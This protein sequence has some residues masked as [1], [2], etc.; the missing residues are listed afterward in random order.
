MAPTLKPTETIRIL[1][2][3]DQLV[4]KQAMARLLAR[5]PEVDCVGETLATNADL[6]YIQDRQ[7]HVVLLAQNLT[8]LTTLHTLRAALPETKI[9]AMPLLDGFG[10][11]KAVLEAGA[12]EC[13]FKSDAFT[14]L[15]PAIRRVAGIPAP[16]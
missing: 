14:E 12:N 8:T 13:I 15:L 4:F 2:L 16:Q 11:R 7:P 6:A 1:L 9:I 10:Y 3:T 5:A